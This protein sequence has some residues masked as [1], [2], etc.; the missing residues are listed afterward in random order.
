MGKVKK[1]PILLVIIP[2]ILICQQKQNLNSFIHPQADKFISKQL[3]HK[4]YYNK[5]NSSLT[6]DSALTKV[7]QWGW[8]PTYNLAAEGNYV[9]I[10]NG[11]LFQVL[12][13][14]DASKPKV[15]GEL[16]TDNPIF[17]ITVSGNY[18][19]TT[20]PFRIID[21]SNPVNPVLISTYL[22]P[23]NVAPSSAITVKGSYA[24]VGDYFGNIF[25]IDVSNPSIPK[26]LSSAR[27]PGDGVVS[28]AV[29]DTVLYANSIDNPGIYIFNIS[30]AD[31]IYEIGLGGNGNIGGLLTTSGGYLFNGTGIYMVIYDISN[32]A[33][34]KYIT[35][36]AVDRLYG[37]VNH[38]AIADTIAYITLASNRIAEVSIADTGNI[39]II[40]YL[41]N[42]FDAPGLEAAGEALNFPYAY[43]ATDDGA[44]IV[45]VQNPDSMS[46]ASFFPTAGY[47]NQMTVDSSYHAYLAE[48]SAGLKILDFSEPSTPKLIGYYLAK[49]EVL[50]VVVSDGY[51]YLDC[52]SDLQVIDISNPASPQFVNKVSFDDTV[53]TALE[54][55]Y[56]FLCLV[57]STIYVGRK[58]QR[59]FSIDIADPHNPR[60]KSVSI[61]NGLPTG[62]SQSNG[63]L[64]IANSDTS[65][66]LSTDIPT[67]TGIEIFNI[68]KPNTPVESGFLRMGSPSG[69]T[70]YENNLY[71]VGEDTALKEFGFEKYDITNPSIPIFKY[72]LNNIAGGVDIKT[73]KNYAYLTNNTTFTVIDISN[74]D[75]GKIIY[76]ANDYINPNTPGSG[77]FYSVTA[78][79]GIVLTGYLGVTIFKNNLIT[80]ITSSNPTPSNFE[81]FQN[82][83]NPFNPETVISYQLSVVSYVTLKI[84]DILGRGVETLVKG[85]QKAGNYLVK[86]NASKFSSG[87]YLYRL[88]SAGFDGKRYISTKKMVL[89]K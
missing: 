39:H 61:L 79:S 25:I 3:Y 76:S 20:A 42:P 30:K 35:E 41:N 59:L 11:F 28:V 16:S 88:E 5:Y 17:T 27:I 72:L 87:V 38:I 8:G 51:A 32:P 84:Y 2:S 15:V 56:N 69:L 33:N 29:E 66:P 14:N 71:V 85:V 75:T 74:A 58:S 77:T 63:Y 1:L 86:F 43:I 82:Y 40:S 89:L 55:Y 24:Y 73:D 10:S 57:D 70:T 53:T 46:S 64:Y 7:G 47:V 67:Y 9:Y 4:S 23:S 50:D 62:I 81:L 19:Y 49:E 31:S 54:G 52:E 65:M 21:I 60:I 12:D 13:V 68:S 22:L 83:P 80:E 37:Y 45:N 48:L 78:F 36:L 44:W 34:P 26:V 18:A 6:P